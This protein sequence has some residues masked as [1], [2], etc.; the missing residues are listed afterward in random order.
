MR[1]PLQPGSEPAPALAEKSRYRNRVCTQ[2]WSRRGLSAFGPDAPEAIS[3]FVSVQ[4][5]GEMSAVAARDEIGRP[6]YSDHSIVQRSRTAGP[7]RLRGA[8]RALQ[9]LCSWFFMSVSPR[10]AHANLARGLPRSGRAGRIPRI[11]TLCR[12]HTFSPLRKQG[13]QELSPNDS[14]VSAGSSTRFRSVAALTC[15]WI[16]RCEQH[17]G[18]RE[19]A[20]NWCA[21]AEIPTRDPRTGVGTGSREHR[22][23][24]IIQ[25]GGPDPKHDV[26]MAMRQH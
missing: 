9:Q 18:T 13:S 17:R 19:R 20:T 3:G 25:T 4:N 26:L 22:T 21:A 24:P 6:V 7:S 10:H 15:G 12:S 14:D 8:Q 23:T 2:C 1:P 11:A 16:C 5:T